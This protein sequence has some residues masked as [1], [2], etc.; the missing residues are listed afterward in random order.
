RHQVRMIV[1]LAVV[2]QYVAGACGMHGLRP[3]LD[4]HDAQATMTETNTLGH[5]H[6]GAVR[7]PVHQCVTHALERS[8]VYATPRTPRMDN[9]AYAA[10]SVISS[11][12]ASRYRP[13]REQ[14]ARSRRE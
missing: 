3:V 12:L 2:N 7:P 4:V 6:P 1:D 13:R 11:P 10:H 5:V 9:P 14:R 8:R